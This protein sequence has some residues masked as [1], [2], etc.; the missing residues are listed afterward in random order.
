MIITDF[1]E[2]FFRRL[3]E[4][5]VRAFSDLFDQYHR[6]IYTLAYRYLKSRE[7][8]E[9]TVQFTFMRVWEQ[10]EILDFSNGVRSLL[11]TVAKNYILNELRHKQ[12]VLEKHSEMTQ[13]EEQHD[14]SF[15]SKFE[16]EDIKVHLRKAIAK[17]PPQKRKICKLKIERGWSNQQVAEELDIS[18]PTV[19]SHY[20][21]AIK[22]LKD[23]MGKGLVLFLW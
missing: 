4:G 12:V 23:I 15:L 11:F 21:Q 1:E 6:L 14:E 9:D 13:E 10:K 8:A 17:L 22:K 16:L 20:T 18:I 2:L 7:E 5:D 3:Q 19:K